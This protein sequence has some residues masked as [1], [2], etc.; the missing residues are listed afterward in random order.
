LDVQ[1]RDIREVVN[2]KAKC[3][4]QSDENQKRPVGEDEVRP[5]KKLR[6]DTEENSSLQKL[7]AFDKG[8]G[9]EAGG[10]KRK[11]RGVVSG[12]QRRKKSPRCSTRPRE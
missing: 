2:K 11:R 3:P 6:R 8:M 1:R 9:P 10:G 5:R 7:P 4:I 12:A